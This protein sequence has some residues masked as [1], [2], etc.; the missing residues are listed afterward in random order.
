MRIWLSLIFVS[1]ALGNLAAAQA[2]DLSKNSSGNFKITTRRTDDEILVHVDKG[3]TTFVVKGS[4]GIGSADIERQDKKWPEAVMLR[5]YLQGLESFRVSNGRVTLDATIFT[6]EGKPTVSVWKGGSENAG[7]D[8]K[9]PFW[10]DVRILAG[11]GRLARAIPLKDGYFDITLP[12]ALF[13]SNPTSITLR[14]ID[15]YR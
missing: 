9:S 5:L 10:M 11:D 1:L 3:K 2:A 12:K 13:E 7:L 8:E 14:W 6:D 15:F 4:L